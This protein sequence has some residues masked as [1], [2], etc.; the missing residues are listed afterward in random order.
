MPEDGSG[1]PRVAFII[2]RRVGN[3]VTRNRLRRRLRQLAR[4]TSLA[5][6]VWGVTAAPGA[7]EAPFAALTVWWTEAVDSLTAKAGQ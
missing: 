4:T 7:A 1:P 3:A 2:G 5:P 6:G